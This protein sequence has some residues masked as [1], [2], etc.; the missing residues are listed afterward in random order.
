MS[1]DQK[2]WLDRVSEYPMRRQLT[3]ESGNVSLVTLERSDGEV[4]VEGDMFS[5]DNLNDL[6][7]RIAD[8]VGATDTNVSAIKTSINNLFSYDSSNGRLVIN[9]DAL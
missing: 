1:F 8:G 6:E 7:Q 3:D 2:T 5:A 9:L 4:S